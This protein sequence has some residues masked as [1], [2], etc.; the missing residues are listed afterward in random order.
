MSEFS[1]ENLL[2]LLTQIKT[3]VAAGELSQETQE[4][5]WNSLVW[6]KNDPDNKEMVKYLFTGWWI[7]QNMDSHPD[8]ASKITK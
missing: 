1:T 2:N 5:M 8:S 7:H 6:D 4:H 3:A